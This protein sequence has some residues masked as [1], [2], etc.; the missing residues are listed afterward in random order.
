MSKIGIAG[1]GRMGTAMAQRLMDQGYEV[2]V[3]NR[4][5]DK[6][7]PLVDAGAEAVDTPAQ[8]AAK[9]DIVLSCLT[10]AGAV[11]IVYRGTDGL[12]AGAA[13]GTV[14]VEMSTV[15]PDIQRTLANDVRTSGGIFVECPVG[16]TTGPARQ[17][18]LLGF[19]GGDE[20]DI[21]RAKPVL[22][23]LCRRIE[24]VGPVGNGASVKLAINL[25]LIVFWQAF[26]EALSLCRDV[27]LA[28]DRTADLF[29]DSSGGPNV[30][31]NRAAAVASALGGDRVPGT[32]DIDSMRKDLRTM[33][34][35]AG[36]MGVDLPIT[37]QTLA[38]YDETA[39]AGLGTC[40]GANEAAYWRTRPKRG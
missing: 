31:K 32:F 14:F 34:A 40:D 39:A 33:L 18:K 22:E 35:E 5:R 38:C 1:A 4:T 9:A 16:G 29:A 25:P 26:G 6:L 23:A 7:D 20:A 30:L 19:V 13:G 24:H 15:Q 10:N 2:A 3:W 8:L 17:G 11:D 21:A 28:P 37:A 12:L 36:D 27:G